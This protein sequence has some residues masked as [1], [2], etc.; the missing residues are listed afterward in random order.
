MI[1]AKNRYGSSA[2]RIHRALGRARR[3]VTP[4]IDIH[5]HI[6]VARLQC[7]PARISISPACLS[8]ALPTLPDARSMICR[9]VTG[10]R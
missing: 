10:G 7:T 8:R 6:L 5:S 4:T 1:S 2:A 3:P 9:S